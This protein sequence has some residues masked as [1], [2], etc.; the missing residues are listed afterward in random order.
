MSTFASSDK[1]CA[2]GST[3]VSN[4]GSTIPERLAAN[5]ALP[6]VEDFLRLRHADGQD[7]VLS[8]R[9]VLTEAER[10]AAYYRRQGLRSGDRVVVVLK[11]SLDLYASFV[12]G[13]LGGFV[14]SIW[15]FPSPKI[16]RAEY[17]KTLSA[18]LDNAKPGVV[19]TYAE[20]RDE[21]DKLASDPGCDARV[22]TP[23]DGLR[24]RGVTANDS[25]GAR[26]VMIDEV[27]GAHVV[28]PDDGPRE[29]D[30]P[31][32]YAPIDPD[33]V[34]LLQYSSG[35]TGIKKGVAISH[36]SL[37]WQIDHYA[38][39][40]GLRDDDRI[41]S[42]LPLY[43]DMGLIACL[44]LP[45][46]T[47]TP[48]VSVCPFE[49]VRQ[50]AM[51]L[52][53][54]SETGGTLSWLPNF[55]YSFL[56][57][58][59]TDAE[60]TDVDLSSLRGLVNCSEP[61]MA[62]SHDRFAERFAPVGFRASALC[63]SYAM[64]EDTFAVTSGGFAGPLSQDRI[65]GNEFAR[66]GRAVPIDSASSDARVL[67]S[68][69]TALPETD[70]TIVDADG[71]AL[72]ERQLGEIVL[73]S[74]CLLSEYY[75]N[76]EATSSALRG[77]EFFTGDI[78]Y[79]ADGQ[80]FVTGRK[81]DML[82]I[83]GQNV[84]PQDIEALVTDTPGV[85]PGRCAVVGVVNRQTGTED[86]VILAETDETDPS[87]RQD[88]RRY[89]FQRIVEA[90]EVAPADIRLLEHMW[91]RKST[92]GKISRGINRDRY[93]EMIENERY[94]THM[95]PATTPSADTESTPHA[96]RRAV[97]R[98]L[99]RTRMGSVI[100]FGHDD[101]LIGR[102]LID[103][104]GLVSLLQAV[105][106]ECGVSI[107]TAALASAENVVTVRS[108]ADLVDRI[109][110]GAEP[111]DDLD[112]FPQ[113]RDEVPL[114]I[115]EPRTPR[116]AMAFWSSLSLWSRYYRRVF[117]RRGVRV[118]RDLRV[119]GPLILRFD[120]D[121]RNIIIGDDVTIMPGVDL[122][123]RENGKIIL[124]DGV[125]LDTNVRL[126]AA[127][128]ARI[129]L[130]ENAQLAMGTIINAGQDVIIGRRTAVAGYC[131]I[132]ASEHRYLGKASFMQQ[133][134]E[135]DPVYIGEDV[136]VAANV[137]VGRGSRIGNGAVLG[138]QS[139]VRGEFPAGGVVMGNPARVVRFR[140]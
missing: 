31:A 118:G 92:S 46:M 124:H 93:V 125:V 59:V 113:C 101:P 132:V 91:I 123:I 102:G 111:G 90:T 30:P 7:E 14:P 103:S 66:T 79:L 70:I 17:F 42:W 38:E 99:S 89:V 52:R 69:G 64:A 105:E 44:L 41:V 86:L 33:S 63:G 22:V 25:R 94:E 85:I 76:P 61:I 24:A 97:R 81:K 83:R 32:E 140:G 3:S 72:P 37:L 134:Y 45:F 71:N 19:I 135:H 23:D 119:W 49:W 77:D 68:S 51:W 67:V 127:N 58:S 13:L 107:G 136:W 10:F 121:P 35:T 74:P 109:R 128:D 139:V 47:R 6:D 36:R 50:P 60:L 5:V 116:P 34:A 56:A 133:G 20:I 55:A 138:V 126:V 100:S 1:N 40:I 21:I 112:T 80:L 26:V 122:K 117:R 137:F 18:L 15:S 29:C 73:R 98:V 108:L 84:Y 129:E 88:I 110:A 11:H 62:D 65:D 2:N 114:V 104:L 43:H 16:S 39:A 48:L 75:N 27:P 115:G 8:Y 57:R 87:S 96:V 120:G 53:A 4:A 106:A 82:I 130:G 12:G 9:T 131:T 54:I 28:T 95:H 78:G